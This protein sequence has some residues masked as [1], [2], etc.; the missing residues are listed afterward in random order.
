MDY[1]MVMPA[2]ML[3]N[4]SDKLKLTGV[5]WKV[6]RVMKSN[7]LTSE[8]LS[9]HQWC[10]QEFFSERGLHQEFFLEG[11]QQIQSRTEGRENRD[12][13]VVAP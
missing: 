9:S 8:C 1:A 3:R 12:L 6:L 2:Q 5:G 7:I 11:V 13:G 4:I 10:T